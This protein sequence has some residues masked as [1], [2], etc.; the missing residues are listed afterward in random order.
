MAWETWINLF[1]SNIHDSVWKE[2][3][4][5]S[6][7]PKKARLDSGEIVEWGEPSKTIPSAASFTK[8]SWEHG[9]LKWTYIKREPNFDIPDEWFSVVLPP[10]VRFLENPAL[11]R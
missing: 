6:C 11:L 2:F 7:A 9:W 3:H 4:P 8:V 5:K 10:D 1:L